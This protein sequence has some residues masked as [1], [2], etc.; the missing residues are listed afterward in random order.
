M[1]EEK[2]II[3]NDEGLHARSATKYLQKAVKYKSK[4]T[5]IKGD[6]EYDG[7]SILSILSIGAYKGVEIILRC[8][9]EDE[10]EAVKTLKHLIENDL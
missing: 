10:R 5:L 4:I 7:K 3:K 8:D 1:V 2:V 9:G 6:R